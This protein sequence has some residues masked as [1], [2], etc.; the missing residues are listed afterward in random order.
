MH[1]LLN[2]TLDIQTLGERR[3][4]HHPGVADDPLVV[5]RDLH[6]VQSDPSRL[7]GPSC[8]KRNL[9]RYGRTRRT[10]PDTALNFSCR[11]R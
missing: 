1:A 11:I 2:K 10:Q 9:P 6:L 7:I 3:S 4:E 8:P 5:K